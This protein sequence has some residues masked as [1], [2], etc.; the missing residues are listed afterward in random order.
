ML[1]QRRRRWTDIE[2][3][4][5]ECLVFAVFFNPSPAKRDYNLFLRN[6]Y[7][8]GDWAP[9]RFF[10]YNLGLGMMREHFKIWP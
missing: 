9:T 2:T 6:T 4:S 7:N 10:N 5:G 8:R 1:G 3:V